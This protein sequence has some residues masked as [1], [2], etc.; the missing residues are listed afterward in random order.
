MRLHRQEETH[1]LAQN[2]TR[3]T[4]RP[5]STWHF[6]SPRPWCPIVSLIIEKGCL[7][8]SPRP[9]CPIAS[10]II[11]KGCLS[12]THDASCSSVP[13]RCRARPLRPF[14]CVLTLPIY[15]H[16]IFKHC[17]MTLATHLFPFHS[18][19]QQKTTQPLNTF[20]G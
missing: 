5:I 20:H 15:Q 13:F 12:P 7:S 16:I 11:E 3:P 17:P 2:A 9:W 18:Y 8:P 4:A 10:L 19:A 1:A 6:P 14:N